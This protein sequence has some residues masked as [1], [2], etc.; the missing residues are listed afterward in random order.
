MSETPFYSAFIALIGRPNSGKSTLLN[1][2]LGEHLAIVSPMPQTTQRNM[3]GMVNRDDMQLIFVDTP[4][5]HKGKHQLNKDMYNLSTSLLNDGD[6]D[7]IC[8]M[9]DMTRDLGEEEDDIA[10]KVGKLTSPVVIVFNKAD[11]LT[12]PEAEK[13]KSDF[14]E[15][16]ENLSKL[17]Q[18]M[19]SS[20]SETSGE[21]FLEFIKPY[22]S[23]GPK[24]YP[25]D[26]L[27]DAPLRFLAA[28]YVRKQV[29]NLTYEEVPHA[30]FIEVT[31]YKESE[32]RH[33]ITADIHVETT[34][35]K[36]III[37][38]GGQTIS[39]IRKGAEWKMRK[40]VGMKVKFKLFVKVTKHWRDK[41]EVLKDFGFD[42]S[43]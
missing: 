15:K 42:Q 14:N 18:I 37:G 8:Y 13:R 30:T 21:V 41:K 34:G 23:E 26:E 5:I 12:L 43:F 19:L 32:E 28:E 20:I 22:I 31:D 16:Y 7:I 3:R 9:V 35:Q 25:D 39:K 38:A 40:L 4:G 1:S 36:G 6:V 29:I 17:P 10:E 11:E 24:Y 33:E 2:L 27:T